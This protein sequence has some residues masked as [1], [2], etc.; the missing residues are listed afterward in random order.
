[1]S[2]SDQS[3]CVVREET[4]ATAP[5]E[6]EAW[7]KE[8]NASGYEVILEQAGD[9]EG[10]T[11][12][13]YRITTSEQDIWSVVDATNESGEV[14]IAEPEYIYTVS[15]EGDASESADAESPS[16]LAT[17]LLQTTNP[18]SAKQW[19][20]TDQNAEAVW[21]NSQYGDTTGEGAV[22]AVIDT[23]VDYTHSDLSNNIWLNT[24]ELTG[25][26]G[27]DDD[28]NGCVDDIYGIN[29]I[30]PYATPQDD[31]GHGTHV[32]GIIAMEDNGVGGIGL[33]Y[34][35]KIMVIKAGGSDG[36]FN[37]SDIAKAIMYASRNGADVINMSFGGAGHSA[38]VENALQDAFSN[39]VLVAA[40][41]NDS[42]PTAD[43]MGYNCYP[44]AYTYV[45]GVMAYD[46]NGDFAAYSNFD[47]RANYGA[48]YEVAAPGSGIYSTLPGDRYASWNGTS[49]AAPVVSACA[50]ILRSSHPD[51]NVYSSRYIMARL[52]VA[53]MIR[54][55]L[56]TRSAS[57]PT[58]S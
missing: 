7:Y 40:A 43:G 49:M 23:G 41:G 30:D 25:Q 31:H 22:V 4:A 16:Y 3:F 13:S 35:A 8:A 44:A 58:A 18:D 21:A 1:M 50:A 15:V 48:E 34:N 47:F 27:I 45:I 37:S 33:A 56:G 51:K 52:R 10:T 14:A 29:L 24:A 5:I 36:S 6:D 46:S 17:S 20:L 19:Y 55:P 38:I 11:K 26:E 42:M 53:P 32:A 57:S 2:I 28:G 39:C 54:S 12:V 9:T